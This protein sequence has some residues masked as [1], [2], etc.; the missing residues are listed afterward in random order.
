M[1]ELPSKHPDIY[2]EFRSGH[3]TAQKTKRVFSAIPVD[4]TH[5]QNNAHIKGD[6]GAIGL[7]DDPRLVLCEGGW[8][9]AQRLQELW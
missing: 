3:F 6:G 7:T 8:F 9:L 5:E 1:T 4:Q 2:R